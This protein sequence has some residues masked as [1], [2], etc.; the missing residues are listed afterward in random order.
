MRVLM[1]GVVGVSG[2]RAHGVRVA[3]WRA[4]PRDFSGGRREF[5]RK[6]L[7]LM[8]V[9]RKTFAHFALPFAGSG[10]PFASFGRPFTGS[11]RPSGCTGLPPAG[12][13]WP[14]H[15]LG[16]PF[17]GS[18][19]PFV[20]TGRPFTGLGRPFVCTVLPFG[21]L[22]QTFRKVGAGRRKGARASPLPAESPPPTGGRQ[23]GD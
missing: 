17:S 20:S 4:W 8:R 6:A 1:V 21:C 7:S 5:F 15:P 18:R 13:G 14:F 16:R 11:E 19:R 9:Q 3:L 12:S 22:G 2:W 23:I 10:R